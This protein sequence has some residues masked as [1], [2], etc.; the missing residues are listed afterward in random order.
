VVRGSWFV[1]CGLWFVV[2]GGEIMQDFRKLRIWHQAQEMCVEIYRLSVDFSPE[3]RYGIT[4]QLRRAAVSVGSNIA[5]GSR[6]VSPTDKARIINI[7]ESEGSEVMSLLDVSDRLHFSQPA[8][9][10]E[11]IRRYD[12][13]GAQIEAFRQSVLKGK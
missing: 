1:V 6:R 12:E 4:S 5:E 9:L 11:M 7:S 13:L 2:C 10:Q 3:E 8:H